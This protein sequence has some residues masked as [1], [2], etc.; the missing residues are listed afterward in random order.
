MFHQGGSVSYGFAKRIH[1][2]GRRLGVVALGQFVPVHFQEK[3][4]LGPAAKNQESFH[5][6]LA[7]NFYRTTSF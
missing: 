3:C 7:F 6:T 5:F 4:R 2:P 1:L